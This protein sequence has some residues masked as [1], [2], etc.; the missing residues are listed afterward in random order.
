MY[1]LK[2]GKSGRLL[3]FLIYCYQMSSL[4]IEKYKLCKETNKTQ[5]KEYLGI[6]VGGTNVKMG[7]VDT[8]GH[9]HDFHSYPTADWR[10][11]GRFAEKLGEA[12]SFK[13]S[14]HKNVSKI[15]IGIPGTISKD[16]TTVL[17]VPAISELNGVKLV[18]IL[19]SK[20]PN[21][22]IA[23]EN[24]ANA[25]A[26]GELYFS[27]EKIVSDYIFVTLGTGVGSA[28]IIDRRIFVGG[29][30]NG[31]ELGHI[32]SRY[33]KRLEENIGKR[34]MLE[35]ASRLLPAYKGKTMLDEQD[36]QSATKLI[37]AAENKDELAIKIFRE[38]GE[39]LGEGLVASIRILDIKTI[40][41]GGGLSATFEYIKEGI[42]AILHKYL[43]PYYL[44]DLVV[45]KASLGNDAGI[46]GAAS[47]C[48]IETEVM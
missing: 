37:L 29:D 45:K 4:W 34:G 40:L 28:A 5:M 1:R 12:I 13:L 26:L 46:L 24:D 15:G 42:D 14:Q 32:V 30:G 47:L 39:I 17:E 48:F 8:D 7:I 21:V 9:I 41:I 43:T 19:H 38:V 22:S 11:T 2:F 36:V 3:I 35:I 18:S 25:A 10:S 44:N 16:R 27:K 6:D 23:I 33:E 31:M 20:V